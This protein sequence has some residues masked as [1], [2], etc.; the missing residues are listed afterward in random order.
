MKKIIL[1]LFVFSL[2]TLTLS[3][4]YVFNGTSEINVKFKENTLE[5][6]KVPKK[7][8]DNCYNPN[9]IGKV[10]SWEGCNGL[11]I[12]N[13]SILRNR[14]NNGESYAD[15]VIFTGQVTNISG[16]LCKGVYACRYGKTSLPYSIKNWD[17]SN[18]INMDK[19]LKGVTYFSQDLS[20]WD[21]SNVESMEGFLQYAPVPTNLESWCTKNIKNIPLNFGGNKENHPIW[22]TCPDIK[23]N[24]CLSPNSIGKYGSSGKCKNLAIVDNSLIRELINSESKYGDNH[25]YTGQVTDMFFCLILIHQAI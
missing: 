5:E 18:V 24:N 9:N 3:Q 23:T 1:G 14:V 15:D 16:L 17:V 22:K 4:E 7:A 2:S 20:Q 12:V 6:T 8:H 25:I 10:G 19:L 21:V 11:L 13:D